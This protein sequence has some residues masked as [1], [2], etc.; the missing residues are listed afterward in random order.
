[1]FNLGLGMVVAV[2]EETVD[3]ASAAFAG[4]GIEP[5]VVGRVEAGHRGIEFNGPPLWTSAT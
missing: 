2:S 5:A 3:V 4:A 1:V